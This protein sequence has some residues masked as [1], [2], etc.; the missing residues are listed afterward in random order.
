MPSMSRYDEIRSRLHRLL[1][2]SP[3]RTDD[4]TLLF[5][6]LRER[7]AGLAVIRE[8]GDFV[9]HADE[10]QKGPVTSE[11]RDFL[12]HSRM[13]HRLGPSIDLLQL[14][15]DFV[16]ILSRNLGRLPKEVVTCETGVTSQV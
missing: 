9:A 3:L 10:R 1:V 11:F 16:P 12:L 8:I 6:W 5:L 4:L 7:A 14:P 13:L 15:F 2:A